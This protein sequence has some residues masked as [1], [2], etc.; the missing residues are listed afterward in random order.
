MIPKQIHHVWVGSRLPDVQLRHID[1]WRQ[2]NPDFELVLWNEGNIDFSLAVL[3]AAYERRLWAKVADI[4]RLKTLESYGGFYLDVGFT[5]HRS[6]TPLLHHPCVL[7]F[8]DE[9]ASAD[10]VANG[11]M[12][13]EPGHRFIRRVLQRLLAMHRLPFGLDRPT[14]YGPS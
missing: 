14:R 6:L 2:T 10:W 12:A 8:Q 4:V 5:L 3:R 9:D 11:I 1:T 7:G 13:A